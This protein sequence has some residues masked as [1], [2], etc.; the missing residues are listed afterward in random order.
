MSFRR[1]SFKPLEVPLHISKSTK[2]LY[3]FMKQYQSASAR[4]PGLKNE[5]KKTK[6]HKLFLSLTFRF[7]YKPV[8]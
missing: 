5:A 1:S 4:L 6:K 8:N 7:L 2:H 3:S